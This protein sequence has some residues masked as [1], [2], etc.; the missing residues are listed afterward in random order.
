VPADTWQ[1][2]DQQRL[3]F[4]ISLTQPEHIQQ[5]LTMTPHLYRASS[6]G[7]ARAAALTHIDVTVDVW[8]R[9]FVSAD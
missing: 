6:E 9:T 4:T 7:R 1:L 3:T 5:L 8:I 2:T